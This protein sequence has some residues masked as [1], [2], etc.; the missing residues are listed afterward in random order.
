MSGERPLLALFCLGEPGEYFEQPEW[1]KRARLLIADTGGYLRGDYESSRDDN[2]RPQ[3]GG[4][5]GE[6][7]PG[8]G[9]PCYLTTGHMGAHRAEAGSGGTVEWEAVR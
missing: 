1:D 7:S 3:G 9:Y 4:P 5:C 8:K 2:P 6:Q